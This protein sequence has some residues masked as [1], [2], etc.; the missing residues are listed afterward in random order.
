[1]SELT[2]QDRCDQGGC[3]AQ[4]FYRASL[5]T[6]A[7]DFCRHHYLKHEEALAPYVVSL[8]DESEGINRVSASSA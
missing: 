4:A 7:L 6:G 8:I 2:R 5:I 3:Q 1:M